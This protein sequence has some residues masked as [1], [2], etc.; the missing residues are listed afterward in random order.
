MTTNPETIKTLNENGKVPCEEIQ[1]LLMAY[2]T[3]ELGE[4]RS[5][6]IR[7][8]IRKCP[9]CQA[10]AAEMQETMDSL[11]GAGRESEMFPQRLSDDRRARIAFSFMHPLL[12]WMYQHHILVSV[13]ITLV[14]LLLVGVALVHIRILRRTSLDPGVPV[15][16]GKPGDTPSGEPSVTDVI[17]REQEAA[18]VGDR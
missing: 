7:E 16:I 11:Q 8:H 10:A 13:L 5:D 15:Q 18:K 1:A 17:R 14:T 4:A 12:D 2:M 9:S 3:R 6:L